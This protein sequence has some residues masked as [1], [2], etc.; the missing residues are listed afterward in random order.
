MSCSMKCEDV[1]RVLPLLL[2]SELSFDEEENAE[3]HLADC[4]SCRT[5]LLRV[6]AL[7][8]AV[9]AQEYEP[10]SALLQQCRRTL[11]STLDAIRETAPRQSSGVLGFLKNMFTAQVHFGAPA[12]S[13]GAVALV[14]MGFFGA[15]MLPGDGNPLH[16]MQSSLDPVASRVRYVEP[17][18]SGRVQII[19]EE[20][21]QKTL[22]GLAGD[23]SIKRLLLE[24]ARDS[25]DP[26]VRVES[27]DLLKSSAASDEVK[28]ALLYALQHD[29][30]AGVR[31]KALEGL[32][33]NCCEAETRKALANVLLKDDNPGVRTQ[34]IDLLTAAKREPSLAGVLQELMRKEDNSYVRQRCRKALH[35]MNASVETF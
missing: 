35:E 19:V 14:A 6:K 34:A 20:T 25:A 17:N 28:H 4:A 11:H 32:R 15:R 26:G 27:M 22:S 5:E 10:N 7:H 1:V 9:D 13:I 8:A 18:S 12:Q 24:A 33:S 30:N 3:Q 16:L 31:L 2:Y 21:R 29:P 23:E